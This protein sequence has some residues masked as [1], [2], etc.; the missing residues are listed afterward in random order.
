MIDMKKLFCALFIMVMFTAN[1]QNITLTSPQIV[2]AGGVNNVE[3]RNVQHFHVT[4]SDP[5]TLVS[6]DELYIYAGASMEIATPL[7][8]GINIPATAVGKCL[9][10]TNTNT[11]EAEFQFISNVSPVLPIYANNSA[12]ASAG[13]QIGRLYRTATGVLMVRY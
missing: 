7:Q 9:T 3:F 5:S 13:L 1:A 6:N 10:L 12:A 2:D 4:A 8:L 11:K